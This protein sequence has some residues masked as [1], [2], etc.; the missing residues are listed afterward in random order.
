MDF[1]LVEEVGVESLGFEFAVYGRLVQVH[2]LT[3]RRAV[4]ELEAYDR[5][6]GRDFIEE[7]FVMVQVPSSLLLGRLHGDAC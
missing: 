7:L 6:A 5:C 3:V 1:L 2:S 4:I